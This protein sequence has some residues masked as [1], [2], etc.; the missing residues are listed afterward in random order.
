METESDEEQSDIQDAPNQGE[1]T[2]IVACMQ[3]T[4]KFYLKGSL[5]GGISLTIQVYDSSQ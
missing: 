1:R 4:S 2:I 5:Q 3:Q